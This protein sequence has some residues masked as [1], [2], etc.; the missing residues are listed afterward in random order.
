MSFSY[1]E[2][3]TAETPPIGLEIGSPDLDAMRAL[4]DAE[5]YDGLLE[6]A[7]TLAEQQIFD[8]RIVIYAMYAEMREQGILGLLELFSAL[9][10]LLN[11]HWAGIGP[12]EKRDRYAKSSLSWL[13]SIIRVDLQTAEL[14]A[15]DKWKYWLQTFSFEDL[16]ALQKQIASLGH[17]VREVLGDA[18]G[19]DPSSRLT[20]IVTWLSELG[21]K[22]PKPEVVDGESPVVDTGEKSPPS[23]GANLGF[24][25]VSGSVHLEIL[26]KKLA[27]F[28]RVME[29]GDTAKAAIIVSDIMEIIEHFDPRLYL[30]TLFS[31]F[32][33]LLTPRINEIYEVL[34]M[35]DTPQFQSLNSLYQVDMEE[36]LNLEL[37]G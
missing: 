20:E 35:R 31:R 28:E 17:T 19:G 18:N 16:D 2:G 33:S 11:D 29:Q 23:S 32:F 15:G 8:I 22:L 14:E 25:A 21:Q 30:P 9:R 27:L 7:R 26:M 3:L 13:F 24:G 1:L 4:A 10:E 12:E 5:D 6:L 37:N 36:F 34:E